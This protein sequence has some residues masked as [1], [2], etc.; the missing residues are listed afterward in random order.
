MLID[1]HTHLYDERFDADRSEA[2]QRA[3]EAGVTRLYLPIAI[4]PPLVPCWMLKPAFRSI[5]SP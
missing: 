4:R 5:A 2:V 1:T 3:I